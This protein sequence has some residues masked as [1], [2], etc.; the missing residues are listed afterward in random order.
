MNTWR[1]SIS[2]RRLQ[3][4]ARIDGL[5]RVSEPLDAGEAFRANERRGVEAEIAQMRLGRRDPLQERLDALLDRCNDLV[6]VVTII[7]ERILRQSR[8]QALQHPVV[9]DDERRNPCRGN[10]GSPARSPA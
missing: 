2:N 10:A 8:T 9:I 3:L 6:S 7:A 4:V 1:A 5:D